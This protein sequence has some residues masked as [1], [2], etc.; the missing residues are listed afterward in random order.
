MRPIDSWKDSCCLRMRK[1]QTSA[2][3]RETP[4]AQCTKTTQRGCALSD[5]SIKSYVCSIASVKSAEALSGKP[6]QK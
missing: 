4:L 1:W 5:W 2:T 3:E 6:Q